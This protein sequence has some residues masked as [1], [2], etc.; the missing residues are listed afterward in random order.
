MRLVHRRKF[1]RYLLSSNIGGVMTVFFG[2][3][4][5]DAIGLTAQGGSLVLPLL[6]TQVLWINLTDGAPALALGVIRRMRER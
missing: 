1:Q 3:L 2:V 4:L 6:A 5:A